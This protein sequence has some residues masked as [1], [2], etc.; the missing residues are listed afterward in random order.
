MVGMLTPMLVA[1]WLDEFRAQIQSCLATAASLVSSGWVQARV[2][3]VSTRWIAISRGELCA[4]LGLDGQG[5]DPQ[6]GV[7]NTNQRRDCGD[8]DTIMVAA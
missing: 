4:E 1:S 5:R 8:D 6:R 2:A 3:F 7:Q